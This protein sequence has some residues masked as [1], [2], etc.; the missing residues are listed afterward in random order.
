[1]SSR[2][3]PVAICTVLLLVGCTATDQYHDDVDA[4]GKQIVADWKELPEVVGAEHEYRHGLDQGQVIYAIATVEEGSVQESVEQLQEIARRD[5]WRGTSRNVSL[6][7]SVYSD[8]NPRV[9]SP[10]GPDNSVSRKR[11]ELD[12]PAGL[13]KQYGPRPARR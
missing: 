2:R 1:M 10:T 11:I 7:V 9:K 12:D 8:A 6:T 13:E 4:V 3:L 5:Y